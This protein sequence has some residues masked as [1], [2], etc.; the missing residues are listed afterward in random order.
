[1][2]NIGL[3]FENLNLEVKQCHQTGN[4]GISIKVICISKENFL[5]NL[6]ICGWGV[7]GTIRVSG[8][9]TGGCGVRL[10]CVGCAFGVRGV[11]VGRT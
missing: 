3:C 11:C 2:D 10:V 9:C 6:C 8:G 1:M 5:S 7:R 4:L